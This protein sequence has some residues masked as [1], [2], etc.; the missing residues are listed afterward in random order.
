MPPKGKG[1]PAKSVRFSSGVKTKKKDV[2]DDNDGDD[3][4]VTEI[5]RP[6]KR[7]R[8]EEHFQHDEDD[9]IEEWVNDEDDGVLPSERDL[10][11]AKRN[12]R[13]KRQG[14]DLDDDDDDE[15]DDTNI[16]YETSLWQ[17]IVIMTI[18][19]R[20]AK[21]TEP[22]AWL[23]SLDEGDKKEPRT[24]AKPKVSNNEGQQKDDDMDD[25]TKEELY[26]RIL[27][28]VSDSET[29]L[30]ALVRYGN[31]IKRLPKGETGS[32]SQKA[33][34]ELTVASNALLLQ[35]DVDI[36]QKTREDIMAMVPDQADPVPTHESR[37]VV[38][39]EY[40]GNQ[41]GEIHGP[42]TTQDMLGWTQAGYFI[43]PQAVQIR[44]VS[45]GPATQ[46]STQ[47]ELLSDLMDDD[48][49][50][51]GDRKAPVAVRGEWVSSNDVNFLAYS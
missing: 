32:L 19:C 31:L 29:I 14:Q 17:K 51:D 22:D 16:N 25:W 11:N 40:K 5:N 27:P 47:E 37:R 1:G 34:D 20:A 21:E 30:Q 41:D 18:S 12:R 24:F 36:Y 23:D 50:E 45:P 3:N 39:W 28:L 8:T 38:Q 26:S 2:D 9:E 13:L 48:D 15:D 35:G 44:T 49:D 43:G 6:K 10:V 42:Y 33:L 7:P 4:V 46:A